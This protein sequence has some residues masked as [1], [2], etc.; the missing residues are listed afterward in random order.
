MQQFGANRGEYSTE[1][2]G[3]LCFLRK[4][5][6]KHMRQQLKQG[7]KKCNPHQLACMSGQTHSPD[8]TDQKRLL[9]VCAQ[10]WPMRT[11][12]LS[13]L[14]RIWC[15][16][17][18]LLEVGPGTDDVDFCCNGTDLHIPLQSTTCV[19]QLSQANP[20]KQ[21]VCQ[22]ELGCECQHEAEQLLPTSLNTAGK[23]S[24]VYVGFFLAA[25]FEPLVLLEQNQSARAVPMISDRWIHSQP[26]GSTAER[27]DSAQ[28]F[29]WTC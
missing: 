7:N 13:S 5:H 18:R 9:E 25:Y 4:Q 24:S 21:C 17:E 12:I 3:L 28:R 11:I 23:V 14:Q 10:Q 15:I 6:S 8:C 22:Q 29:S 16:P 2:R 26:E 20:A 1:D 19:A 27:N